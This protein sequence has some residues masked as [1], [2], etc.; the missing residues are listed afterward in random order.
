M[1]APRRRDRGRSFASGDLLYLKEKFPTFWMLHGEKAQQEAFEAELLGSEQEE[2]A[3]E[4]SGESECAGVVAELRQTRESFDS[5]SLP[6]DLVA[7][8]LEV[9][10]D[11]SERCLVTGR[12]VSDALLV[13]L[14]SDAR[15]V[16]AMKKEADEKRLKGKVWERLQARV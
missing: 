16:A 9:A 8:V 11:F 1:R 10:Y 3:E 13:A 5:E 7:A 15:I 6:G 12:L 4:M 14:W 2:E